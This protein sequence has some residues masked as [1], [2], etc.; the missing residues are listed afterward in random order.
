MTL[1]TLL[2]LC[3]AQ[4]P[5][6][7]ALHAPSTDPFASHLRRDLQVNTFEDNRQLDPALAADSAGNWLAAW[8]SRRQEMGTFGVFAQL[9]DP[10]G[11]DLSTEI[12][13]NTTLAGFQGRPSVAFLAD[14]TAWIAWQSVTP[15]L[16]ECGIFARRFGWTTTEEGGRSFGPLGDEVVVHAG[17]GDTP[18]DAFLQ[19]LAGGSEW[20]VAWASDTPARE[21]HLLARRYAADGAPLGDAFR[22]GSGA[23]ETLVSL[24]ATPEGCV[25][26]WSDQ[27]LDGI[28][29]AIRGAL[30]GGS[31]ALR[32]FTV[33]TASDGSHIE[34]CVSAAA[35]G[36]FVVAWMSAQDDETYV[37]RAQRFSAAAEPLGAPLVVDAGGAGY[38]CGALVATAPDGRFVVAYNAVEPRVDLHDGE[39][40]SVPASIRAQAYSAGGD[41]LGAPFQL[42]GFDE[43]EQTL[44]VGVNARHLLWTA[45][46]Q[47]AAAWHG[48]TPSGDARGI[49]LTLFAPA[50]FEPAAPAP[51]ARVAAAQELTADQVHGE[52]A[53]PIY[54]PNFVPP[55]YV[56]PPPAA[57]GAGGFQGNTN[58]G[59]YPPDPDL[60]V[61]PNHVVAV[62]NGEIAF[63][64]KG[65][66]QKLFGQAIAGG[67]GFWGGQGAGGFVFDPVALFDPYI[68]RFVVAA[69]DG[70]GSNDSICLAVSDDDD[71]NGTWHKYRFVVYG[72]CRFLDF[73]NLG[74][75]QDSYFL[76]GDCFNSGGN[77][78]FMW[79]KSEVSSGAPSPTIRQLQANG[80]TQS[81]G[82]TKNYDNGIGYFCT[83]YSGS[84]TRLKIQAVTNA[85]TSPTLHTYSLTVPQFTHPNDAVQ[86]GTS[87]RADTI[88]FRIKNGVVRNGKL[89][90]CH[91]NGMNGRSAVRW[92]QINLNGWPTSGSP[93]LVQSGDIDPGAGVY[94]WFGDINVNSTD[95]AVIAFNRSS[96]SQ[97]ISIEYV[98]RKAGDTLG[99]MR[100]PE[101]LQ[102]STGPE[103]GSRY[104]DYSG[105]E[106]DPNSDT[107]FWS[108]HEFISS[109]WRT[110]I[111]EIEIGDTQLDLST[112]LLIAGWP[113]T[114]TVENLDPSEV[115]TIFAFPQPGTFCPSGYGGLCLELHPNA[116]TAGSAVAAATGLASL[117][118]TVPNN[119]A[120]RTLYIQAAA[121]RGPG[122]SA[123][124]KSNRLVELVN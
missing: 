65:T 54:N 34:P 101:L 89:W 95:D 117:T 20:I 23:R 104:G 45:Q 77:R 37:A 120:G 73:P 86:Q 96:S 21:R 57:G 114:L 56:A 35:D 38:R 100:A 123:S 18:A 107:R 116:K 22:L 28:P 15:N 39:R 119:L 43:G 8:G 115:V 26:V 10:L 3:V 42:N 66:G 19:P 24:D 110:W 9:L 49:G 53:Y 97:Y 98:Y 82:A 78:I 90:V 62:V 29:L 122:G 94:T 121:I 108:D 7:P 52:E 75:S 13:V 17:L 85:N 64:D 99:A 68:N 60:A 76:A 14:G 1:T 27:D 118:R 16:S 48:R 70:A 63:F 61:G 109:G 71:P 79:D 93:S 25:A 46:D 36:S 41:A 67:G 50:Q 12:H 47:F 69:A 112:T 111:G 40:G 59:W 87:N 5:A 124:V 55:A 84:S 2:L 102:V 31:A 6:S 4:S 44:Q 105:V 51:I 88:D 91:S 58:T 92:Y 103:T 83:T 32:G 74:C 81:L 30:L 80:S 113:A 11:R 33:A 106:L 72:T